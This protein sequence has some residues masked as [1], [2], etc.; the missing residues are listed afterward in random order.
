MYV[1]MVFGVFLFFLFF[2]GAQGTHV[3]FSSSVYGEI[4]IKWL[5]SREM[6]TESVVWEYTKYHFTAKFPG[7]HLTDVFNNAWW[8]ASSYLTWKSGRKKFGQP[9]QMG[10]MFPDI[11]HVYIEFF[12]SPGTCHLFFS[13][14]QSC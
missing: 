11:V 3:W 4:A 2:E 14:F 5:I 6:E 13:F 8:L 9:L 7:I 10:K 12:R 1:T